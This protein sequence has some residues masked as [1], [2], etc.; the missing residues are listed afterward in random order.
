LKDKSALDAGNLI[1]GVDDAA[2]CPCI[3]SI[4]VAGVVASPAVIEEWKALGVKDSKLLSRK[5]RDELDRMIR[6]NA[7]AHSI[8]HIP[9]ARIDDKDLNLNA[10]EMVTLLKIVQ[11]MRLKSDFQM[12]YVD[13]WEV[14][15]DWFDRRLEDIL[16]RGRA[17]LLKGKKV[18]L[19]KKLLR[20][21][22]FIPEHRADETY[23]IV[24]AASI[25]ARAASDR[26][27]DRLRKMYGDIGSG[28]PGDPK[29]RKFVWKHRARPVPIIRQSWQTYKTLSKIGRL[30]DD[31]WYGR[32]KKR[33]G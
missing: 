31:P 10:W 24:S 8:L 19:R 7:H 5:R 2:K 27:Y 33:S 18:I 29:T 22:E 9:P 23:T 11:N 26:Q 20:R 14:S 30:L 12:V 3:G 28:S 1:A 25:L 13:N 15:P 6:R 4:F 17:A 21:I 32:L 16:S